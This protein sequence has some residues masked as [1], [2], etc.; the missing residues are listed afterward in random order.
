MKERGRIFHYAPNLIA[1]S[2][3]AEGRLT[4]CFGELKLVESQPNVDTFNSHFF[5]VGSDGTIDLLT[6]DPISRRF[7]E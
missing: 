1:N 6:S 5:G 4:A 7:S 2:A 3:D